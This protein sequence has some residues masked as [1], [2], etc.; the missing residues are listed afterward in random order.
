MTKLAALVVGLTVNRAAWRKARS[1]A[2]EARWLRICLPIGVALLAVMLTAARASA[3]PIVQH[4]PFSGTNPTD[5]LCGIDGAS[6]VTGLDN[7]QAFTDGRLQDQGT[8]KYV[9]TATLTGKS[10]EIDTAFRHTF[11]APLIV[12]P[13]GSETFV[14]SYKGLPALIKLPNG[15]TLARDAGDVNLLTTIDAEGNLVSVTLLA[16]N[17]PHPI[18]DSDGA[19]ACDVI[20]PALT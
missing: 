12:N 15:M 9:F 18:A 3:A 11:G 5:N 19:L 16:E 14:E 20:V 1:S 13:D 2:S 4:L 8:S 7:I 17:G 10:V 6:V